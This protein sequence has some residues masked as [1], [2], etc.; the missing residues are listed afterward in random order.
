M[1]FSFEKI[2]GGGALG[3]RQ[4]RRLYFL[5]APCVVDIHSFALMFIFHFLSSMSNVCLSSGL[6][7]LA[8]SWEAGKETIN[9]SMCPVLWTFFPLF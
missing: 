1:V 9:C 8:I 6:K 2:R 3:G 4:P 7:E 5:D